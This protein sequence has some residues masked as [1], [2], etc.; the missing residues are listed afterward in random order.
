[1]ELDE[2]QAHRSRQIDL[3]EKGSLEMMMGLWTSGAL[4]PN[5]H[6][7]VLS[8]L[9]DCDNNLRRQNIINEMITLHIPIHAGA[10]AGRSRVAQASRSKA[11]P[12]IR[13]V[14]CV[15]DIPVLQGYC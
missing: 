5:D 2:P 10:Y 14:S 11:Y 3:E 6:V 13:L 4:D 12:R 7:A 15:I 9:R 1:M 8:A